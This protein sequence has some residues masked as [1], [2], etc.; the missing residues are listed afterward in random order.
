MDYVCSSSPFAVVAFSGKKWRLLESGVDYTFCRSST[1]ATHLSWKTRL[2]KRP[3]A[4][5][6]FRTPAED[7]DESAKKSPTPCAYDKSG[8][9]ASAPKNESSCLLRAYVHLSGDDSR[10]V[11]ASLVSVDRDIEAGKNSR[12]KLKG[13]T[14][15]T[16][17]AEPFSAMSR[18]LNEMLGE[19]LLT[20]GVKAESSPSGEETTRQT[21]NKGSPTLNPTPGPAR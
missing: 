10:S 6:G 11:H 2:H 7:S 5:R 9:H 12:P 8:G 18:T 13:K 15:A 20:P 16:V 1:T 17:A 19:H 4:S 3:N 14:P 21:N